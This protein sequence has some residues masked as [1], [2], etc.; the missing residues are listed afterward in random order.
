[1]KSYWPDVWTAILPHRDFASI[2]KFNGKKHSI[3]HN[4]AFLLLVFIWI[5]AQKLKLPLPLNSCPQFYQTEETSPNSTY[6]DKGICSI[7]YWILHKIQWG[8]MAPWVCKSGKNRFLCYCCTWEYPKSLNLPLVLLPLDFWFC[9]TFQF[10][11]DS[12]KE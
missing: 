6:D 1:M 2:W 4:K 5:G 9:K 3:F 10:I 8:T 11:L 7:L 12:E